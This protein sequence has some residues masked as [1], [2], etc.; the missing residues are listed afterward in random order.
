MVLI[1]ESHQTLLI[2]TLRTRRQN[3]EQANKQA[4]TAI[5]LCSSEYFIL[6]D[7]WFPHISWAEI[8]LKRSSVNI[9]CRRSDLE[10]DRIEITQPL[11]LQV[12]SS[13]ILKKDSGK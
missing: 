3:T 4:I 1:I 12:W 2:L 7:A 13:K 6:Q 11:M 9:S 8:S 5:T 10:S